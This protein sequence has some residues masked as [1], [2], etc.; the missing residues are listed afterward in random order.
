MAKTKPE[1]P[2]VEETTPETPEQP[3][4]QQANQPVITLQSDEVLTDEQL[5]KIENSDM[6]YNPMAQERIDKSYGQPPQTGETVPEPTLQPLGSGASRPPEQG[7]QNGVAPQAGT[8][9]TPEAQ[10][11]AAELLTDTI[12]TGYQEVWALPA[13]MVKVSP[14]KVMRMVIKD[15]LGENM[16]VPYRIEDGKDD[17]VSI[18][19]FYENFNKSVDE[20]AVIP[21]KHFDKVRPAMIRE[22]ARRGLGMSDMAYI[23]GFFAKDFAIRTANFFSLAQSQKLNTSILMENYKMLKQQANLMHQQQATPPVATPASTPESAPKEPPV[24]ALAPEPKH[25]VAIPDGF[26]LIEEGETIPAGDYETFMNYQG[27]G[28]NITNA[29][30]K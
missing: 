21:D 19:Q 2:T 27:T 24:I 15:E 16:I 9:V 1:N 17:E 14:E 12:I 29:P 26:R 6:S 18:H 5:M 13:M 3:A 4:Q 7:Q 10:Q 28:K 23:I 11:T 22:A 8:T 25:E 20:I 30:A